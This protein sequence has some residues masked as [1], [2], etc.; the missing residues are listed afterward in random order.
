[1]LFDLIFGHEDVLI[2]Y[3]IAFYQTFV[4]V[5]HD[6]G[7]KYYTKMPRRSV[8]HQ[9]LYSDRPYYQERKVMVKKKD[10]EQA[11]YILNTLQK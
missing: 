4:Q 7:I 11:V 3:D 8:K 10:V 1:M 9:H 5:L 2:T 6:N